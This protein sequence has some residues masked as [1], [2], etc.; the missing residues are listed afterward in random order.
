[1]IKDV[2]PGFVYSIG[3]DEDFANV[4]LL[5]DGEEYK[6]SFPL[7]LLEKIGADEEWAQFVILNRE[8]LENVKDCSKD[9]LAL[10]EEEC[11]KW[12]EKH[13]PKDEKEL[14]RK[15]KKMIKRFK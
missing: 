14:K 4:I 11:A 8:D 7:E 10:G 3:E 2:I 13:P 12:R 15:L 6:Y 1:M 5:K 9:I